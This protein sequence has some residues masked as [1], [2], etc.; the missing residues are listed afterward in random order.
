MENNIG[1]IIKKHRIE[2]KLKQEEL[3]NLI[4]VDNTTISR[5]ENDVS[6]PDI[7]CLKKLC[8]AFNLSL[9]ELIFDYKKPSK[10][11]L[12][13]LITSIIELIII[14]TLTIR[15][16]AIN[17]SCYEIT[18]NN[19]DILLIGNIIKK[20][21]NYIININDLRNNNETYEEIIPDYFQITILSNKTIIESKLIENI[22]REDLNKLINNQ[23]L[24]LKINKKLEKNLTIQIRYLVDNNTHKIDIPLKYQ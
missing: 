2:N 6:I 23:K 9:D 20:K 7:Y 12:K 3:A 5:W 15:I 16:I 22:D 18:S 4:G 21:N 14:I 17:T 10:K 19:K 8:K 1:Q 11:P 13:W 24:Y